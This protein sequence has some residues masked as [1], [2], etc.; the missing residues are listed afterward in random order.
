MNQSRSEVE[1]W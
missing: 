1:D